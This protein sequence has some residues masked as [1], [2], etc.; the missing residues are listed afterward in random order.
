MQ[1]LTKSIE[2]E[3]LKELKVVLK[4]LWLMIKNLNETNKTSKNYFNEA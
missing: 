4:H 2:R 3:D 1:I